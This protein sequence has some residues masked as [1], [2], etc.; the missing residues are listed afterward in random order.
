MK[1]ERGWRRDHGT[2][3]G[4]REERRKKFMTMTWGIQRKGNTGV[5]KILDTRPFQV[6]EISMFLTTTV[7]YSTAL[8]SFLLSVT[9]SFSLNVLIDLPTGQQEILQ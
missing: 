9:D 3:D 6:V 2:A 4:P 8:D 5:V 1:Q 7:L